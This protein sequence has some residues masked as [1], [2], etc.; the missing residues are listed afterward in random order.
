MIKLKKLEILFGLF[1]LLLLVLHVYSIKYAYINTSFPI[2]A[3]TSFQFLFVYIGL[4]LCKSIDLFKYQQANNH[5]FKSISSSKIISTT[6]FFSLYTLFSYVSN[7]S[8]SLQI[9]QQIFFIQLPIQFILLNY[10]RDF[11][12]SKICIIL[13]V[14]LCVPIIWSSWDQIDQDEYLFPLM[15]LLYGGYYFWVCKRYFFKIIKN[16]IFFI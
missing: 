9:S 3:L 11:K 2:I 6:I 10:F 4:K 5:K 7:C 12:I 13:S 14:S 1:K 16:L 8:N 15:A